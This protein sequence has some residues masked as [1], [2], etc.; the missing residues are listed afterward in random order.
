MPSDWE[1][2]EPLFDEC[3]LRRAWS[4]EDDDAD[5]DADDGVDEWLESAVNQETRYAVGLEAH[6]PYASCGLDRYVEG[7]EGEE[8]DGEE[9]TDEEAAEEEVVAAIQE[10]RYVYA[11][12]GYEVFDHERFAQRLEDLDEADADE[13][14]AAGGSG[15]VLQVLHALM[16]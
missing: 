4:V 11:D 3:G 10:G 16:Q 9:E 12:E 13:E 15:E 6:H 14:G 7:E 5:D 1:Q 2:D 8:D